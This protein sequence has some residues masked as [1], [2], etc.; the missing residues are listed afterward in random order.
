[1]HG[2]LSGIPA[3]RLFGSLTHLF[4][5]R[6]GEYGDPANNPYNHPENF[7]GAPAAA[8]T[9]A[10]TT[11]AAP[12]VDPTDPN[13]PSNYQLTPPNHFGQILNSF[14]NQRAAFSPTLQQFRSPGSAIGPFQ[15]V[16]NPF[17]NTRGA[18]G[19]GTPNP[20]NQ[21]M[22]PYAAILQQ[23]IAAHTQV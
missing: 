5:G 6:L 13:N 1:M 15:G 17:E 3:Y 7:P 11:P 23:W 16:S 2:L 22:S 9:P 21:G 4:Q 14:N 20:H 18:V 19:L 10:P 12:F 8:G